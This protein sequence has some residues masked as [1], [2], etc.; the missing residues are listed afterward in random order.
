[1]SSL[2][3][4]M[5]GV[6]D[7]LARAPASA[8]RRPYEAPSPTV[9]EKSPTALTYAFPATQDYDLVSADNT[10][11]QRRG[12]F[13]IKL[14]ATLFLA[15]QDDYD[16][17]EKCAAAISSLWSH[18]QLAH[19]YLRRTR[20]PGSFCPTYTTQ[21]LTAAEG[22]WKAALG[23]RVL[24][25]HGFARCWQELEPFFRQSLEKMRGSNLQGAT[26]GPTSVPHNAPPAALTALA[27]KTPRASASPESA[28]VAGAT[29][30]SLFL[31][32]ATSPLPL[33]SPPPLDLA[34]VRVAGL[35]SLFDT[36]VRLLRLASAARRQ[37]LVNPA[38]DEEVLLS[39]RGWWPVRHVLDGVYA[40][41]RGDGALKVLWAWLQ[42]VP[43][44]QA[45]RIFLH[46]LLLQ[47]VGGALQVLHDVTG[48]DSSH[49]S[50]EDPK[51]A[52]A[53][54]VTLDLSSVTHVR[55]A[56]GHDDK[57]V[58]M[59]V[60][61]EHTRV[62]LRSLAARPPLPPRLPSTTTIDSSAS[63]TPVWFELV[64]DTK[65]L[66]KSLAD[67]GGPVYTAELPFQV[68]VCSSTIADLCAPLRPPSLQYT[69]EPATA[70]L[71]SLMRRTRKSSTKP[72]DA[73]SG[74]FNGFDPAQ[75]SVTADEVMAMLQPASSFSLAAAVAAVTFATS[76]LAFVKLAPHYFPCQD[77]SVCGLAVHT[78][79]V[80]VRP[81]PPQHHHCDGKQ[82]VS[83]GDEDGMTAH[84]A[85]TTQL[86]VVAAAAPDQSPHCVLV[87][88]HTLTFGLLQ[89]PSSPPAD[90]S[91]NAGSGSL[92]SLSSPS[93]GGLRLPSAAC[94][95]DGRVV[96]DMMT[97]T[98]RG[99][100]F[101]PVQRPPTELLVYLRI[102][103]LWDIWVWYGFTRSPPST[104]ATAQDG[105][106]TKAATVGKGERKHRQLVVAEDM[107]VMAK[108]PL[109]LPL[110]L[111][112]ATS[113]A[114]PPTTLITRGE[115]DV[116][117]GAAG[118]AGAE[119]NTNE[120][121]NDPSGATAAAAS[122]LLDGPAEGVT[123]DTIPR[124]PWEHF[125]GA[126]AEALILRLD[127]ACTASLAAA[128]TEWHVAG[129]R[130]LQ[131]SPPARCGSNESSN[132][133]ATAAPA[134]RAAVD[135][136]SLTGTRGGDLL[137]SLLSSDGSSAS[138]AVPA[139]A[140]V[141]HWKA[142]ENALWEGMARWISAVQTACDVPAFSLL[143]PPSKVKLQAPAPSLSVSLS[144]TL[145]SAVLPVEER[146]L[147][148]VGR[149]K[150]MARLR[151]LF[152][153]LSAPTNLFIKEER[154]YVPQQDTF[155]PHSLWVMEDV[156]GA[157][158][159][160]GDGAQRVGGG[161][162]GGGV[163][164]A[165]DEAWWTVADHP[166]V[167]LAERPDESGER[168][169]TMYLQ[170]A[171]L[172]H[173]TSAPRGRGTATGMDD[174]TAAI[175]VS[176]GGDGSDF[177][178]AVRHDGAGDGHS[179]PVRLLH[180]VGSSAAAQAVTAADERG[181][182]A[183]E[184]T[185]P[186][187]PAS[188]PPATPPP[189]PSPGAAGAAAA[190]RR[191]GGADGGG[192]LEEIPLH[193]PLRHGHCGC[194]ATPLA[195]DEWVLGVSWP[196]EAIVDYVLLP[197]LREALVV[198]GEKALA[199]ASASARGRTVSN[200][201]TF[202]RVPS[203]TVIDGFAADLR[204]ELLGVL[205]DA[206]T[207]E[208]REF[209]GDGLLDYCVAVT[210]LSYRHAATNFAIWR[211]G[212][213]TE[214]STN[215]ALVMQA[216]PRVLRDYWMSRRRIHNDKRLAD[217]VESLFGAVSMALWVL[218]LRRRQ[219]RVRD[220]IAGK[221][222]EAASTLRGAASR[223]DDL[224]TPDADMLIYIASALL[225]LLSGGK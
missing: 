200:D 203:A 154:S 191:G 85:A 134:V 47:N 38:T 1:M 51:A 225:Q 198:Y 52:A 158:S 39:A 206:K 127:A 79:M 15:T 18:T 142:R 164:A 216:L 55:A 201:Y 59:A 97:Y 70:A 89:P 93:R 173:R 152:S 187:S 113:P 57:D 144:S 107:G 8:S 12:R 122:S 58:A 45:I 156:E 129:L 136:R 14:A 166:E 11:N 25:P 120:D 188:S 102:A 197:P 101:I 48:H 210:V 190:E 98:G 217:C 125:P 72:G 30:A 56:W 195:C 65:V 174:A 140:A 83:V 20:L 76:R 21:Q 161:D 23:H 170:Q 88:P 36:T 66:R 147:G 10:A 94:A 50:I 29:T 155:A 194:R 130:I 32:R 124:L 218:P 222:E 22:M 145:S 212:S 63:S 128:W 215:N 163:T 4:E 86:S 117:G 9:V 92:F 138:G 82:D 78:H 90:A 106:S 16:T 220:I 186:Q 46:L 211:G 176:A 81:L 202:D 115:S 183:A 213:I 150:G 37:S 121:S 141:Q 24:E 69:A 153:D 17:P 33:S 40:E 185:T 205:T 146:A 119:T 172:L 109:P 67:V 75:T 100:A 62:P 44:E 214:S 96:Y 3:G 99:G 49:T 196:A 91:A 159:E 53:V 165:R 42:A 133:S 27:G 34:K 135:G 157:M 61:Q 180:F 19:E 112:F 139:A 111:L 114:L 167:L 103:S 148:V 84:M 223:S 199:I 116:E 7:A 108:F 179:C 6:M 60:L 221:E 224:P 209:Y 193:A 80:R 204:H 171:C 131:T 110:P 182:S 5:K 104:T 151:R 77:P 181:S 207:M 105:N 13:V 73:A 149:K 169:L 43:T 162:D 132:S 160:Q 208:L 64:K 74:A 219:Q 126:Q 2:T 35:S 123:M 137:R 192:L 118:A 71:A 26:S 178:S 41:L 189:P 143:L 31:G 168:V 184:K 28:G 175:A 177:T 54:S 87:L 68:L 95:V